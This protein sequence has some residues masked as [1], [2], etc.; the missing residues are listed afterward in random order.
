M[1]KNKNGN[2]FKN[3]E[4][5]SGK[6]LTKAGYCLSNQFSNPVSF[7]HIQNSPAKYYI[8]VT[9][10]KSSVAF[11]YDGNSSLPLEKL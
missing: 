10:A 11:V 8:A 5:K 3:V 2:G 6:A 1:L 7:T 4:N 9:R